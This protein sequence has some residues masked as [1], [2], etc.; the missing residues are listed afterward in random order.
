MQFSI[1]IQVDLGSGVSMTV[2]PF[3]HCAD[4]SNTDS[5]FVR[6][7]CLAMSTED[8]LL[9]RSMTGNCSWRFLKQGPEEDAKLPL[10]PK[11]LEAVWGKYKLAFHYQ[12]ILNN[13]GCP[14][15]SRR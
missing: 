6:N 10:T 3:N 7:A 13:H 14:C 2:V 11:K 5:K 9:A 8:E 1:F 12:N 15:K 4:K